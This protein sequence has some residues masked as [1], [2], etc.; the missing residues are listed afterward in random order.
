MKY[1]E[2]ENTIKG[3]HNVGAGV[4]NISSKMFKLS[5]KAILKHILH[6]FNTCLKYGIFTFIFKIA[7]IKPIFKSRDSQTINN[8]R[9]ISILP[10]MSKIL[11]KL[12]HC[13]LIKHLGKNHII[14]EN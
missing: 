1:I 13:R 10:F 6:L 5:Y 8:Y 11:D 9:P 7:I 14:H 2:L 3:P 12:I 4:D